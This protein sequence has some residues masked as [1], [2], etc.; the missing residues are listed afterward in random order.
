MESPGQSNQNMKWRVSI[1]RPRSE[2]G[3]AKPAV[4]S[5]P[6]SRLTLIVIV[7]ILCHEN[8]ALAW[9]PAAHIS[10]GQS[11]LGQLSTMSAAVA[12]V[13]ARDKIAYLYGIIAADVVFA[14]RLSRVKQSCHHWATAFRLLD[15]A[16]SN[17]QQAFAYGYLSHLAADTVA[18]GL[19]VPH[20]VITTDMPMNI[21]HLY[22]ELRADAVQ[23]RAHWK[24]LEGMLRHDHDDHHERL[25][26][27]L[28]G[29]FLPY[30]LNRLVFD[31]LNTITS[32][33][34]FRR[35]LDVWGRYSSRP[36]PPPLMRYYHDESVM[37]MMAVLNEGDR[38]ALLREDPN[39][40]SAMMQVQVHRREW[41][42][43]RRRGQPTQ[44]HKDE[45]SRA[46]APPPH[47]LHTS[48]YT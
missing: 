33:E 19:Y 45:S 5:L 46:F 44:H 26:G 11:L 13:L 34:V 36:L 38:C 37:R 30:E 3:N 32:A 16:E 27:E 14:K 4:R 1:A 23:N 6:I 17:R 21:G 24:T 20:Q 10:M 43:R 15:R 22:W 48:H 7:V 25:S 35:T 8:V 18:H 39:G 40:T 9:G 28:S 41:R 29:T 12:A 42:K 2:S 47:V 31:G